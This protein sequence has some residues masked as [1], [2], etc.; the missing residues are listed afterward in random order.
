MEKNRTLYRLSIILQRIKE[1]LDPML[2]ERNT[3]KKSYGIF[4]WTH[5]KEPK[6]DFVEKRAKLEQDFKELTKCM[7]ILNDLELES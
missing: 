6:L 3:V 2:S 5:N 4:K 7:T 1:K